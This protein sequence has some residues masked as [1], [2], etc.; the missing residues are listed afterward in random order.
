MGRSVLRLYKSE[1]PKSGPSPSYGGQAE[2]RAL[3]EKEKPKSTVRNDCATK[4]NPRE[5][6]P[7]QGSV[8]FQTGFTK[9]LPW[10]SA[11]RQSRTARATIVTTSKLA[12]A[13]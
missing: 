10:A 7:L 11:P 8:G 1:K 4:A 12:S 5:G 9:D 2:G 3:H 6:C 13:H